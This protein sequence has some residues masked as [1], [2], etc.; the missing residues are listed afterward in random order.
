[1]GNHGE[2]L[3]LLE[4]SDEKYIREKFN[5][6]K[7]IYDVIIIEAPSLESMNKSKEWL[8]FANK[9]IGVFEAGQTIVNGKKQLV[10]YLQEADDKFA[11]WVL[12]KA[13]YNIKKKRK[14]R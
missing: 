6:L 12:N 14:K 3:T 8:L 1:L 4:I 11:G 5:E 13:Y 2:D 10:K 7:R 9:F